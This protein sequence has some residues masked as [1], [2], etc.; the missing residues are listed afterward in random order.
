MDGAA[1]KR[2]FADTSL[3]RSQ[4]LDAGEKLLR[5]EDGETFVAS[6]YRSADRALVR[7]L[8]DSLR[9][10]DAVRAARLAAAL[11]AVAQGEEKLDFQALLVSLGRTAVAPLVETVEKNQDWQTVLQAMDAL[12]KLKAPEG[13]DVIAARLTH[14]NTWV[15]MGAAHALGEIGAARAVPALIR[16]L[17]DTAHTVVSAA[18]VG[19]GRSGDARA[20]TPCSAQLAHIN[21]R[22]RAAAASAL[23]RLGRKE[24]APLL[25]QMLADP[26]SGVRYKAK[27]ALR[28]LGGEK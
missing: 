19:L 18:L 4:R 20:V 15:R 3:L 13:V 1:L 24:S 21:P 14:P 2:A 8:L 28:A 16:A 23:G 10:D 17:E 22:V 5:Q 12:G 7:A 6:R 26:D 25:E 9:R 11:L 27:Q